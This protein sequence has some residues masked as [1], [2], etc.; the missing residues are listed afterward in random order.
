MT[1]CV[2]AI[3]TV[4]A[5]TAVGS[6]AFAATDGTRRV[7]HFRTLLRASKETS[8][9]AQPDA[10]PAL[11]LSLVSTINEAQEFSPFLP[12]PALA[13]L[14]GA[15]YGRVFVLGAFVQAAIQGY[16]IS[17]NQ[18]TLVRNSRHRRQFCVTATVGRPTSNVSTGRAWIGTHLIVLSAKPFRTGP[19]SWNFPS[20]WVLRTAA[21][22]VLGASRTQAGRVTGQPAAC[23]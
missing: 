17:V 9:R 5:A 16:T 22:N 10:K 8:V 18:V 11:G 14:K 3:V 20:A 2:S 13:K 15:D 7:E 4:V 1:R 21:G 12:A 6:T 19:V 23:S